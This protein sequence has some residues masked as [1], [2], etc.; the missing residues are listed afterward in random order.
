[1]AVMAARPL[2]ISLKVVPSRSM[3]PG[4]RAISATT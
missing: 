1:M 2:G 4:N 3:A